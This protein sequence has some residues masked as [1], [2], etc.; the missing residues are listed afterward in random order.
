MSAQQQEDIR[1][2]EISIKEVEDSLQAHKDL[3]DLQ[4]SEAFVR[5]INEGYLTE[6]ALRLT[7]T[8][9]DFSVEESQRN[10]AIAGLKAISYLQCYFR[11]I[12]MKY[13]TS[14][15]LLEQKKEALQEVVSG[16]AYEDLEQFGE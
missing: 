15:Q 13:Q 1:N 14:V 11:T 6:E 2:I 12:S 9:S 3:I 5:V 10:D 16:E 4:S 7:S 8:L